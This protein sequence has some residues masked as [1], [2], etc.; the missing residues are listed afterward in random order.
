MPKKR[1]EERPVLQGSTGNPVFLEAGDRLVN[2]RE[3][4]KLLGIKA[5][6]LR[7]WRWQRKG[8]EYCLVERSVRYSL[9]ALAAYIATKR[10]THHP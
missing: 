2:E 3:A 1:N 5:G 4:G 7:R 8:P 9:S 10:V 6:T